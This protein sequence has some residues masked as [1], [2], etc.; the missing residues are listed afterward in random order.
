MLYSIKELGRCSFVATDGDI[1]DIK[2][3]QFDDEAWAVRYLVVDIGAWLPG[4]KV[5]I[6]SFSIEHEDHVARAFP[7]S[8]SK[9]Q[10]KHS[11][12]IDTQK[13]CRATDSSPPPAHDQGSPAAAESNSARRLVWPNYFRREAYV[14]HLRD[15]ENYSV[16]AADGDIRHVQGF[17]VDE[18][19]WSIRYMIVDT[20][21]WW[22]DHRVLIAPDWVSGVAWGDS[23]V[24]VDLTRAAVKGSPPCSSGSQIHR[25]EVMGIYRHYGRPGY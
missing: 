19:T 6:S 4:R 5:L 15:L 1:G 10:I 23:K 12:S 21:N 18:Q 24:S 8:V 11:P 2:D 16:G 25:D 20:T 9:E 14:A 17:L 7:V 22:V 3:F 13:R